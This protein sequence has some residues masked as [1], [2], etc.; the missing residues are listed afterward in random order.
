M[1]TINSIARVLLIIGGL[2]WGLVGVF[3]M[4]LVTSIFGEGAMASNVVYGLVGIA[5][6][7]ELIRLFS[8]ESVGE[9]R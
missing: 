3:R 5:A 4:N 7:Y 2:N 8:R 6:L 9:K 1:S